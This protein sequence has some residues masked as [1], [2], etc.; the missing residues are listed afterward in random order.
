[1][2]PEPFSDG[3]AIQSN[4]SQLFIAVQFPHTLYSFITVTKLTDCT[5]YIYKHMHKNCIQLQVI[6]KHE[7]SQLYCA[8]TC[9]ANTTPS[10]SGTHQYTTQGLDPSRQKTATL[11]VCTHVTT[12]IVY[13][14]ASIKLNQKSMSSSY[15]P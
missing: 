3:H 10:H 5:I 1:M 8:G 12:S 2:N 11:V 13:N 15:Q 6:Y 4:V 7:P 9:S 14:G